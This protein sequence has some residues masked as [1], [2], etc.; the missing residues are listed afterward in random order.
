MDKIG[1][2]VLS[3]VGFALI[4]AIFL[5]EAFIV[6]N[7]NVKFSSF[8]LGPV[9][10]AGVAL[11]IAGAIIFGTDITSNFTGAIG[12]IGLVVI[13]AGLIFAW[14]KWLSGFD[15]TSFGLGWLFVVIAII[16]ITA[17][18]AFGKIYSYYFG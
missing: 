12:A 6:M 7:L 13:G 1:K 17:T 14:T 2:V 16:G 8:W 10:A 15:W 18:W 11:L 4:G 5:L 9:T 3:T